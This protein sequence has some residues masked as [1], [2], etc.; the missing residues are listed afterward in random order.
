MCRRTYTLWHFETRERNVQAPVLA[1]A[2]VQV[3]RCEYAAAAMDSCGVL[4]HDVGIL[5]SVRDLRVLPP[6][7]GDGCA[8]ACDASSSRP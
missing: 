1:D 6:R 4:C 3:R 2:S 5:T 8:Y 7:F